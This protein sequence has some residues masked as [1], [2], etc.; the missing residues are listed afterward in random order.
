MTGT[1]GSELVFIN[2]HF[3]AASVTPAE[4][5]MLLAD[6]WRHFGTHFFRYSLNLYREEVVRVIPLRIR[7]SEFQLSRS[8]R[9]VLRKN[10]DLA[11]E[12]SP[13][14]ITAQMEELFHRHKLR[15]DH[16]VPDSIYDFLSEDAANYPTRGHQVTVRDN[17]NKLL[18]VSFLDIGETSTSA[19]YASFDPDEQQRSLGIFT[20]LKAI[21]YSNSQGR[22]FYYHGYSYDTP[23]FYDYKFGF[24]G[25]EAF[26]W[27]GNWKNFGHREHRDHGADE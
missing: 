19:I 7:L 12:I 13:T 2:E 8:H 14:E 16:A 21:E 4:L 23:S 3:E 5:D 25:L 11:V 22:T 9:R 15:F 18:A 20:M 17:D 24:S 26:D 6:G 10:E 1:P 27:D